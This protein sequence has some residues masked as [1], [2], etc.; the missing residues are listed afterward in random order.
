MHGPSRD[1]EP[2]LSLTIGRDPGSPVGSK[3]GRTNPAPPEAEATSGAQSPIMPQVRSMS[4]L[5]TIS[6]DTT[7]YA[8]MFQP[9]NRSLETF[10]TIL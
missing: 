9:L 8:S 10:I 5:S 1:L 7:M 2:A 3:A 6:Q 4:D